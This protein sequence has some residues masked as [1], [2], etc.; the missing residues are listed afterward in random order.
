MKKI[1]Y[2]IILTLGFIG[3]INLPFWSGYYEKYFLKNTIDYKLALLNNMP[4]SPD[5]I[6]GSGK[7]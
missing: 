1:L 4:E 2:S 6:F 5:I 3:V 7:L